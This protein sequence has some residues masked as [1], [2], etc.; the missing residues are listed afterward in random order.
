MKKLKGFTLPE[1][2][3]SYL[4]CFSAVWIF[5]AAA[6]VQNESLYKA[7]QKVEFSCRALDIAETLEQRLQSGE[8][9]IYSDLRFDGFLINIRKDTGFNIYSVH[10][11]DKN[12]KNLQCDFLL[13]GISVGGEPS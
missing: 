9:L 1:V 2:V 3:F 12:N 4:I 5:V 6:N 8:D 13:S 10:I 11:A 7:I